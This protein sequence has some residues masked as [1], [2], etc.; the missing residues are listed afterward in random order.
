MRE[1]GREDGG[2]RGGSNKLLP[3]GLDT[4]VD[5]KWSCSNSKNIKVYMLSTKIKFMEYS[6]NELTSETM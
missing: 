5:K 4:F 3:V 1:K 2:G 6:L